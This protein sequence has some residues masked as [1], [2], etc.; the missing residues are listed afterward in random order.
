MYVVVKNLVLDLILALQSQPAA[1]ILPSRNGHETLRGD[2]SGYVTLVDSNNF[3]IK[4]AIPL[5][6]RVVNNVP[7]VEIWSAVFMVDADSKD[8]GGRTPLSWA[9]QNGYEAVVKLLLETGKVDAD[10]KD[11]DGQTPLSWA[12][13]NGHEAVVKLLLETGKVDA[14][15][16]DE[17]KSN[18]VDLETR[19]VPRLFIK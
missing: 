8:E 17:E 4:S 18:E 19:R 7:D 11:E 10:S 3:D 15:S 2:L 9:A 13:Q 12:A 5:V 16:K 6:E 14:D 1:R